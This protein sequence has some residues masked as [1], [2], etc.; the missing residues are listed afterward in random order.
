[1]SAPG[2]ASDVAPSAPPEVPASPADP[3][4]P[5]GSNEADDRPGDADSSKPGPPGEDV[6]DDYADPPVYE[7]NI[8]CIDGTI[9]KLE[10][11]SD[12][13]GSD[14]KEL[15]A[16][17]LDVPVARQR[18]IF[19]GR[20]VKDDDIIGQHITENGLTLHMVQRPASGAEASTSMGGDEV[21]AHAQ[22]Q[23]G[24]QV[25][26]QF[27]T[28][29]GNVQGGMPQVDLTQI[30]GTVFGAVGRGAQQGAGVGA[31]VHGA[32]MGRGA[33]QPAPNQ[34]STVPATGS[35]QSAQQP[36]P[37][38][39]PA[40]RIP[41]QVDAA[42]QG[43]T[44]AAGN[45]S[46]VTVPGMMVGTG[47]TEAQQN[48]AVAMAPLQIIFQQGLGNLAGTL[49]Q[50]FGDTTAM[51]GDSQQGSPE[52]APGQRDS[53]GVQATS[54]DVLPWR[55]LRRLNQHLARLLGRQSHH[56]SLIPQ[57]TP[58]N[59]LYAFLSALHGVTSQLGVA[60]N[61]MQSSLVSGTGPHPRHRIQFA[62]ALTSAARTLRGMASVMQSGFSE[63]GPAEQPAASAPSTEAQAEETPEA[64]ACT[65]SEQEEAAQVVQ[66]AETA[67]A[68]N[69][70]EAPSTNASP[71]AQ[72]A[73]Q[74]MQMLPQLFGQLSQTAG[75]GRTGQSLCEGLSSMPPEVQACWSSWTQPESFGCVL[76][77]A[78][79]PPFSDSYV[80]GDATSSHHIPVLPPPVEYL[81]LR[82]RK[83]AGRVSALQGDEP[84]P[85]DHL[86]RAYL[87]AFLRDL[88]EYIGDNP[89]F[90]TVP[91]AR[92]RYPNL[93]Q[94]AAE[95]G[96]AQVASGAGEASQQPNQNQNPNDMIS[97]G[98]GSSQTPGHES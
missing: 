54:A 50:M 44:P 30:L 46:F 68:P 74:M 49:P 82:W 13:R 64:A 47:G 96:S 8:K 7:V 88:G 6:P 40:P 43:T 86:S 80:S 4:P 3:T 21:G 23:P 90:R 39:V 78:K 59:E 12:L 2:S 81:P 45:S 32:P 52:A 89:T 20:V 69:A 73:M 26:F 70:E 24:P 25:H 16:H 66:D 77:Q 57:S 63:S 84:P 5:A 92:D 98:I 53:Q 51:N 22:M 85:P 41:S 11:P 55:D 19:R 65:D 95:F 61:D 91:S 27:T 97:V 48:A 76:A 83:S 28:P 18:L 33:Q 29:D 72:E 62:M 93:T 38:R 79:Q 75:S 35:Q 94:L 17:Q 9:T 67:E 60:I 10:V 71:D 14:I 15:I 36:P 31:V 56:R 58:G 34:P 37:G 87:C 42:A 1:M